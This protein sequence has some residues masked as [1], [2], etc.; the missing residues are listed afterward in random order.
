M[1]PCKQTL[2]KKCKHWTEILKNKKG[3][4]VMNDDKIFRQKFV[5]KIKRNRRMIKEQIFF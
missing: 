2:K 1:Y 3:V 4:G 5:I